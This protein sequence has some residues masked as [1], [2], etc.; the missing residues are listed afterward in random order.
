MQCN[1]QGIIKKTKSFIDIF[2]SYRIQNLMGNVYRVLLEIIELWPTASF[3]R[4]L[5]FIK[6]NYSFILIS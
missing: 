6:A 1:F 3:P 5:Y 4:R 2:P